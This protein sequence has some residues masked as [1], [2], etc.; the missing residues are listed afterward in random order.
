MSGNLPFLTDLL[1]TE[2]QANPQP[3]QSCRSAGALGPNAVRVGEPA[4]IAAQ[5]EGVDA[6]WPRC[7][8]PSSPGRVAPLT[9]SPALL[10]AA[11]L[12]R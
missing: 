11:R 10:E 6:A 1:I 9:T 8:W 12:R 4:E 3:S 2:L 5:A 7:P